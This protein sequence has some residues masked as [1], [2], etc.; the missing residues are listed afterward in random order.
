MVRALRELHLAAANGLAFRG[1]VRRPRIQR[2]TR[3]RRFGMVVINARNTA[4]TDSAFLKT[5][6]TSGSNIT[7][8]AP[9]RTRSANRFGLEFA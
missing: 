1:G 7:A 3:G 9:G 6:A 4:F 8:T 2:L 5:R